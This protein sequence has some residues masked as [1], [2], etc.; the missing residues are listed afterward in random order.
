MDAQTRAEVKSMFA[1]YLK[2]SENDELSTVAY[3]LRQMIDSK[4]KQKFAT[5]SM[6][7][8]NG[9]LREAISVETFRTSFSKTDEL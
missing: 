4:E 9:V 1:E 2:F 3:L 7:F 5:V 6:T 8:K